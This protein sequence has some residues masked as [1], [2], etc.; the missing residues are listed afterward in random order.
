MTVHIVRKISASQARRCDW[1]GEG[2][3]VGEEYVRLF[4]GPSSCEA[5]VHPE[6]ENARQHGV[7]KIDRDYYLDV[8]LDADRRRGCCCEQQDPGPCSC[9]MVWADEAE[10][11]EIQDQEEDL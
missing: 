8:C 5:F 3:A 11:D 1:C 10:Q 6:C 9:G 7:A 4:D 2:I